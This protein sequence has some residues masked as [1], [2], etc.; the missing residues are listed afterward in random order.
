MDKETHSKGKGLSKE[1]QGSAAVLERGR[2][3]YKPGGRKGE[4]S[5]QKQLFLNGV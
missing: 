2:N 3:G 1:D 4:K 5:L